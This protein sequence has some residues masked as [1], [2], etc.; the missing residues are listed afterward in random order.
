MSLVPYSSRDS[1]EIVLWVSS[2]LMIRQHLVGRP[3]EAPY[4]SLPYIIP[5]QRADSLD[6]V[7]TI[8]HSFFEIPNL[9]NLSFAPDQ[10][11]IYRTKRCRT[12]RCQ[13]AH[14]AIGHCQT[15][16][17]SQMNLMSRRKETALLV[18][19]TFACSGRGIRLTSLIRIRIQ[20]RVPYLR[21]RFADLLNQSL[22]LQ[23]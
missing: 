22:L 11:K 5:P 18:Q 2:S 14:T 6:I 9:S 19:S 4:T 7:D 23:D 8:I 15:L 20:M 1:R 16:S 13:N 21:V 12:K 3:L 10:A 17:A